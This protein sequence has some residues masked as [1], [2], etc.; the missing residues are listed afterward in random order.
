MLLSPALQGLG[1]LVAMAMG[2][3]WLCSEEESSRWLP[4][5]CR[6]EKV[7]H[8]DKGVPLKLKGERQ[9]F[10]EELVS[11]KHLTRRYL[12]IYEY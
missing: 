9:E 2:T 4:G 7:G 5:C 3:G 6:A 10:K 1:E 11:K 12:I 8:P